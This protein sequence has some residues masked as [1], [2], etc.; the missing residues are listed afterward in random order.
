MTTQEMNTADALRA[1]LD[2]LEAEQAVKNSR[3]TISYINKPENIYKY[4]RIK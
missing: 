1:I 4:S 3:E 2:N